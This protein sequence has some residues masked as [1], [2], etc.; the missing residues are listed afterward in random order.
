MN[1]KRDAFTEKSKSD[2]A[3][4]VE[5]ASKDTKDVSE[6]TAAQKGKAKAG[7]DDQK[8][9]VREKVNKSVDDARET[10]ITKKDE[11]VEKYLDILDDEYNKILAAHGKGKGGGGS[12]AGNNLSAAERKKMRTEAYKKKSK[13]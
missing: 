9:A 5:E 6:A 13:K 10:F 12:N 3:K 7:I 8:E 4:I 11:I 2:K 1:R